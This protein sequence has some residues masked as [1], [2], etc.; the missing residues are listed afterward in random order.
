MQLSIRG[1]LM[2]QFLL[3]SA[4]SSSGVS[5]PLPFQSSSSRGLPFYP[6][7]DRRDSSS[8]V[9]YSFLKRRGCHRLCCSIIFSTSSCPGSSGSSS[10]RDCFF[11]LLLLLFVLSLKLNY[12]IC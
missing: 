11:L 3:M 5:T 8:S 2:L 6:G 4:S 1:L 12:S 7:V 10:R 9:L